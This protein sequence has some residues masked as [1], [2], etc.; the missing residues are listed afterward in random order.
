M[1]IK[2]F[3]LSARGNRVEKSAKP[4]PDSAIDFTDIPQSTDE[5]LHRAKRVGRPRSSDAKLLIAIRIRSSLLIK[6]QKAAKAAG[7]PYQTFI[8]EILENKMKE[9]R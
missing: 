4:I 1:A 8:H 2:R 7:K 3:V 6:I 5:E 9:A